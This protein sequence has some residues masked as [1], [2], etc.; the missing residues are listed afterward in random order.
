MTYEQLMTMP[1]SDLLKTATD[2]DSPIEARIQAQEAIMSRMPAEAAD[3]W[4][5]LDENQRRELLFLATQ[6][7]RVA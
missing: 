4:N 2:T 6:Y 3:V 7:K 1:I 5:A